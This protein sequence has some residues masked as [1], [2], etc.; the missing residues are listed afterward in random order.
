[1]HKKGF[2]LIELM[3]VIAIIGILATIA[4]PKFVNISDKAKEAAT[5][6]NLSALRSALSIYHADTDGLWP[7]R[8]NNKS[9]ST[10]GRRYPAFLPKYMEEIPT[11]KLPRHTKHAETKKV[12]YDNH[13]HKKD[14]GCWFYQ[15]LAGVVKIGCTHD[16]MAKTQ[17]YWDY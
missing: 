10:G 13:L 6:A 8:L 16:N 5:V 14:Y 12:A 1:M 3:I 9:Y 2:T 4:I 15:E 17:T 7:Y 11:M